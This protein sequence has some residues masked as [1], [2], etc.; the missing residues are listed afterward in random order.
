MSRCTE[1]SGKRELTDDGIT[2]MNA[3]LVS[4]ALRSLARAAVAP[5]QR[6]LEIVGLQN[7][8]VAT[9]VRRA[10]DYFVTAGGNN[11]RGC[12]HFVIV[13]AVHPIDEFARVWSVVHDDNDACCVIHVLN[14]QDADNGNEADR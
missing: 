1:S 8:E 12:L 6:R 4:F 10:I 3:S 14:L 11:A 13:W 9:T 5:S 2:V 7:G